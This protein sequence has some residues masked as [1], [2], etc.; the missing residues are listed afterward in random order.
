VLDPT[1]VKLCIVEGTECRRKAPEGPDQS[2]LG[3]DDVNDKPE[4]GLLRE[5]EALF[6]CALHLDQ[7]ITRGKH[8]RGQFVAAIGGESEVA[9]LVGCLERAAHQIAA[10]PNMFRPR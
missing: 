7:R 6:G 4:P 10:S 1:L 2:E 5:G 3:G 9:D 8:V